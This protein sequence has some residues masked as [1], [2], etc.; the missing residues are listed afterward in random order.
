[1]TKIVIETKGSVPFERIEVGQF[2]LYSGILHVK[3]GSKGA[4]LEL[5][6]RQ[7]SSRA[8]FID[9]SVLPVKT[10]KAEIE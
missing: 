7:I 5:D 1:M 2:F 6:G 9:C 3:T 10:L 8:F 4:A